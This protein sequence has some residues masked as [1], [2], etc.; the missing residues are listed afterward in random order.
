MNLFYFPRLV[1]SLYFWYY[2]F[3]NTNQ[4]CIARGPTRT[5]NGLIRYGIYLAVQW[6]GFQISF[7]SNPDLELRSGFAL[8]RPGLV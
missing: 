6:S 2:F 3:L 7:D 5:L 1:R 4:H 8:L